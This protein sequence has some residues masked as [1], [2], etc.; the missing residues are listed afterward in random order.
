MHTVFS[1]IIQKRFSQ[2]NEDVATDALAYILESSDA[3]RQGLAKLLRSITPD[4]PLLRFKTQQEEG[5]IRP[6]MWGYADSEP[7]VFIE[8]K[9]WAGLTDNQPVSYLR[10]LSTYLQPTVLLVVAPKAREL[11]LWRELDRRLLNA[12]IDIS[13]GNSSGGVF[14][15][16]KTQLGPILALASWTSVLSVLEDATVD[17]PAAR[18]DLVQLRA[19]CNVADNE[20]FLPV[21]NVELSDQRTPA[22]ILQLNS[23]VQAAVDLAVTDGVMSINR[24]RP[25]ASWDRIGR[26]VWVSGEHCCGGWFGIHFGLW[27]LHGTTPLWLLFSE[28]KFGRAQEVRPL[29]EPWA[30]K[31]GKLTATYDRNFAMAFDI[32][33]REERA[34]VIR[35]L[36]VYF[37]S[38]ATVLGTL[39]PRTL[40]KIDPEQNG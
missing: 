6:D 27:K 14:Q 2:I 12:N 1:H 33:V 32:P 21:S 29:I 22:F 40:A 9:F 38:I 26:Y 10:Q 18:G 13:E 11:T 7:R 24:L 23:I 19:L 4:L 16:V 3:A 28:D 20:A 36:A 25:Q 8:N 39:P 35:S 15:S 17:D 30:E 34:E 37:K 5:A 31:N